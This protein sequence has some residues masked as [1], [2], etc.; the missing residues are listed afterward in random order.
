M[1]N[2]AGEDNAERLVLLLLG[3]VLFVGL[4]KA[5]LFL[6]PLFESSLSDFLGL[7][8]TLGLCFNRLDVI[9]LLRARVALCRLFLFLF[10]GFL[11]ALRFLAF[12]LFL[13]LAFFCLL[14]LYRVEVYRDW[15]WLWSCRGRCGRRRRAE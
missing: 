1:V 5:V 6:F 3:V 8:G 4:T 15:L 7:D 11:F 10:A 9:L 2:V 13:L 12:L 14:S